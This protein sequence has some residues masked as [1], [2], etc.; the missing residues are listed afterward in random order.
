VNYYTNQ[1]ID[2]QL[3]TASASEAIRCAYLE[4]HRGD[5]TVQVRSRI[6][7]PE[8]KF[9]SMSA[10]LSGA[11]IAAVKMYTTLGGQFRF[12][13]ALLSIDDGALLAMLEGDAITRVRT[14][15]TTAVAAH[16]LARPSSQSL[17]VFGSGVQASEHAEALAQRF[18]FREAFIRSTDD[19]TAGALARRLRERH[20][21]R[22]SLTDAPRAAAADIVVLA[23][24]ACE[25]VI[26]GDWLT[27]GAFVASIGAT[28]PDQREIDD[29]SIDMAS[30]IVVDWSE[31]TPFE[32]GDL[33]LPPTGLID[34][35]T[36][37]DLSA[38][39]ATDTRRPDDATDIVIYKATGMALQDAAVAHLAYT[40]LVAS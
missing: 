21:I 29:A 28:R 17:G 36:I 11:R 34:G 26:R 30:H 33:L 10:M 19:E 23:T 40:R 3:D 22:A 8:A 39:I 7:L 20:G 1:Q 37:T 27:P 18:D 35:K 31:Q 12:F 25:P 5:A 38:I 9:S 6:A 24:R 4:W 2:E 15:A 16:H 32:T 14:A 13:I